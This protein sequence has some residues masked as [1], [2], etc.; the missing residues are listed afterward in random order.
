MKTKFTALLTVAA[1]LIA[2]A[3]VAVLGCSGRS[4]DRESSE[5]SPS[6]SCSAPP[7]WDFIGNTFNGQNYNHV[8]E[9]AEDLAVARDGVA[10]TAANWVESGHEVRAYAAADGK[11]LGPRSGRHDGSIHSADVTNASIY[12]TSG[13][14]LVRWDRSQFV[15]HAGGSGMEDQSL[16]VRTG[17]GY[18]MGVAACGTE[19][20]LADPNG[21]L[22]D[23]GRTSPS[24]TRIK[25]VNADMTG[26]VER[27]WPAP[28]ARHLSCDRQGNVWALLQ[29]TATASARLVRYSPTGSEL[30]A[31]DIPG[32]PMDVAADPTADQVWVTDNGT[33]QNLKRYTY[34]GSLA[35]TFG[36]SY[37]SGSSPGLLGPTRFAGPRGV[38]LDGSG[39][40]YVAQTADAG[41]GDKGW[42]DGIRPL[43]LSKFSPTG[44]Q[45][46]RDESVGLGGTAEAS[47]DGTRLY[48]S[49]FTYDR[50]NGRW[51]QR[52]MNRDPNSTD[53]RNGNEWGETPQVRELSGRRYVAFMDNKLRI[54][55]A[56]GELLEP[57]TVIGASGGGEYI[58][59][60]GQARETPPNGIPTNCGWGNS[61]MDQSG[62]IWRICKFDHSVW[63]YRLTGFTGHNDPVYSYSQVDRYPSIPQLSDAARIEVHGNTLYVSGWGP[64]EEDSKDI[65]NSRW[66]GKRIL[67]YSSLP[68]AS[69]WPAPTWN[70]TVHW[71]TPEGSL[72]SRDKP[73][74][75]AVD[76]DKIAMGYQACQYPPPGGE[77]NCLHFFRTSDGTEIG[78]A[79][80]WPVEY[81]TV[82]WLDMDRPV[83]FKNGRVVVEDDHL[84]K[85]TE[86]IP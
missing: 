83:T 17:D 50:V 79:V 35:G 18:L 76:G 74:G 36:E 81:G 3:L 20:Y 12:A 54:Y 75:W 58:D 21:D 53:L 41:F 14:S 29:R 24:T 70:K 66:S 86:V 5:P 38:G 63:R 1:A 25:V 42:T 72:S 51:H 27:S 30:A 28:R 9:A 64:G 16:T 62:D 56:E 47:D 4:D 67:K 84:A 85:F 57:S 68:T 48:S 61:Y 33:A 26:G 6:A 11:A 43:T 82:G 7:C 34:A 32:E 23:S 19:V 80:M 15:A 71:G 39:N 65:E 31:F 13:L 46:W 2:L 73:V 78:S 22:A 55:R 59:V 77:Q 40:L 44:S 69:G 60:P 45:I 8:P 52:A 37:L 10:V 49:W